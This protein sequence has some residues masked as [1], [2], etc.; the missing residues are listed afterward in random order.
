MRILYGVVGEGMGHATRSRVLLEEL[1]RQHE[2]HIVVS[3]RAQKYLEER[4]ASVHGIWGLTIAYAQ[5]QVKSWQTVLQNLRGA[6]H[7]WPQNVRQYFELV[8]DFR[9]DVVVSDFESF[10]YLF[11]RNHFL[12]VISVDNMQVMNRCR[13]DPSLLRGFED[14]FEVSRSIVKSKLPGC[15][16]YLVTTFFRPP[17]R[18]ERTTLVPSILRPEIL[19]ATSEPGDH[20][21]VYQSATTNAALPDLLQKLGVPCRIYGLR[22]DLEHDEVDGHLT[23]RPFSEAQFIEDLRTC[24]GVIA[25]GGFT[26]MSEA[27][28]LHKPMLSVPI[29]GQFEQV[30]N[31]LYVQRLGYGL[32]AKA[33]TLPTLEEFLEKLPR[34]A[35]S[36]KGYQQEGNAVTMA[37]LNAQLALAA[38]YKGR[39]REMSQG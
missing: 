15:F 12:P 5:N 4:F 36:L 37:T 29:E 31:A 17:L 19:A 33:L 1:S 20:L 32:H 3:G 38:E 39:W 6:V 35:E 9:P 23:Y 26:L 14:P 24:R 10:S 25:G 27:V 2:V 28:Y 18:K 13:H 30:L 8:N 16:H 21:L 22:R 7:G 11:G 34:L